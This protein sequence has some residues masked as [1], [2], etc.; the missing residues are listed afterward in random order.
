MN[1]SNHIK[2]KKRAAAVFSLAMPGLGQA[3]NGELLKGVCIAVI[4]AGVFII[5]LKLSVKLPGGGLLAGLS[6]TLLTVLIVYILSARD[7]YRRVDESNNEIRSKAYKRWYFYVA[8]WLVGSALFLSTTYAYS[9]DNIVAVYK[10]VGESMQPQV[11]R[12]DWVIVDKTA[13]KHTAPHKGDIIVFIYPDDRS[14]VYIKRIAA[15]PG[16]TVQLRDGNRFVVPHGNVYVLGDNSEKSQDSKDF[17]TIQLRDILGKARQ[18][19]YSRGRDGI[20]WSRIGL[21]ID[22]NS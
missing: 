5:G 20:R 21:L 22:R 18:V 9:R 14:K 7:A 19:C 13:Y 16:E 17:G 15:L 4:Y 8:A 2:W 6:L 12:G 1:K 10:I 3:Y 11:L